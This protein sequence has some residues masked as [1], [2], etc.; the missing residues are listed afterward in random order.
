MPALF[1]LRVAAVFA[2]LAV[3]ACTSSNSGKAP[4]PETTG[5]IV[6]TS[7]FRGVDYEFVMFETPEDMA[8][9]K[10]VTTVMSALVG[11]FAQ[12]RVL[13]GP[14]IEDRH[15][16]MW[17]T[18]RETLEGPTSEDGSAYVEILQP[19]C[20][21][22]VPC[23]TVEDFAAA[24]PAGTKV[25]VLGDTAAEVAPPDLRYADNDAGRP[26]GARLVRPNPGGLLFESATTAGRTVVGAYAKIEDMPEAWHPDPAAGID[27]LTARLKAAGVTA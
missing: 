4:G 11:G 2:V 1:L 19:L 7:V 9:A 15:V 14:G 17:A 23:A 13:A 6:D 26:P 25:L 27:G 22:N 20:A 24:I 8:K 21:G 16:V 3:A 5:G 18:I 10:G 12:G